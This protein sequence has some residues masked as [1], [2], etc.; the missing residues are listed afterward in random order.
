MITWIVT[1]IIMSIFLLLEVG[2]C[3]NPLK[4]FITFISLLICF[5]LFVP[6][7][8]SSINVNVLSV[9]RTPYDI[10]VSFDDGKKCTFTD[11]YTYNNTLITDDF[12]KQRSYTI[13]GI[14]TSDTSYTLVKRK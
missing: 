3:K 12:I 4:L 9:T 5:I 13:I 8:R 2:G 7:E 14:P 6:Y 1:F 10:S 11:I